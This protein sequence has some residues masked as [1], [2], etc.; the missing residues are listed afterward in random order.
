MGLKQWFGNVLAG[1]KRHAPAI[2]TTSAISLFLASTILAV[3][4][5]PKA[6]EAIE[7]KKNEDGHVNLTALQVVQVTWRYY[8]HR[9]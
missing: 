5:T 9:R 3:K 7:E 6:M 4:A 1:A 8:V 2:L